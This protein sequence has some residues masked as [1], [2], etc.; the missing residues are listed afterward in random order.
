MCLTQS[1][2]PEE[3]AVCREKDKH[4]L[5]SKARLTA[6]TSV[7]T[8]NHNKIYSAS[9][10]TEFLSISSAIFLSASAVVFSHLLILCNWFYILAPTW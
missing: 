3:A 1:G 10:I 6:V 7:R 4:V 2:A 8:E 9:I 5:V